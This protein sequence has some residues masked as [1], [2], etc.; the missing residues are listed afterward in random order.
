MRIPTPGG[1]GRE[2]TA[3]CSS[4]CRD[5]VLALG[6]LNPPVLSN[7][8]FSIGARCSPIAYSSCGGTA[9]VRTP[10]WFSRQ[11]STPGFPTDL[12]VQEAEFSDY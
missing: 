2:L 9:K 8:L 6:A 12:A 11:P 1:H 4:R 7:A 5:C 10:G 3:F